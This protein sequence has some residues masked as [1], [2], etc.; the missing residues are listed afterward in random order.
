MAQLCTHKMLILFSVL[1]HHHINNLAMY[2]CFTCLKKNILLLYDL[3]LSGNITKESVFE[4]VNILFGD[5]RSRR[6]YKNKN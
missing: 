5:S 3:Y 2:I 1:F 4:N 6:G